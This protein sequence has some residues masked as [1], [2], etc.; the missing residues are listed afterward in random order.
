MVEP[1]IQYVVTARVP[2]PNERPKLELANAIE[3]TRSPLETAAVEFITRPNCI[4][5]TTAFQLSKAGNTAAFQDVLPSSSVRPGVP[6]PSCM[7]G[8]LPL[9]HFGPS[10][11]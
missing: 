11:E 7:T 6:S 4:L 3:L 5:P 1:D 9:G 2:D 10:R 8:V